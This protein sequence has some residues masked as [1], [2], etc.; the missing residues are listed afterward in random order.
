VAPTV[1][2]V[3]PTR[4]RAPSLVAALE[5]A[6]AQHGA[7]ETFELEVI[8]VD[9][10]SDLDVTP[11]VGALFP[12]AITSR[13]DRNVG[14]AASRNRALELATGTYVAFLDD[15]DRW[16]P[17]KTSLQLAA[18]E[19]NPDAGAVY[20]QARFPGG[21]LWPKLPQPSGDVFGQLLR[22]PISMIH[23]STLLVRREILDDVGHF[24]PQW[25]NAGEDLDL[26]FRLAAR[27]QFEFVAAAVTLDGSSRVGLTT[28]SVGTHAAK[29]VLPSVLERALE[30]VQH[31]ATVAEEARAGLDVQVAKWCA[32]EQHPDDAIELLARSL[33]AWPAL[34]H[35]PHIPPLLASV[36]RKLAAT[37]PEARAAALDLCAR[38]GD[39]PVALGRHDH[40]ARRVL[41]DLWHATARGALQGSDPDRVA[42]RRALINALA[43]DPS[44]SVRKSTWRTGLVLA[45][46]LRGVL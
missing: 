33:P 25:R 41:A 32:D 11:L 36:L 26:W 30:L 9:D 10:A 17:A 31:D 5:S 13:F 44:T 22:T 35:V 34:V 15:D 29:H 1:S 46:L 38:A 8:V 14:V 3:V 6:Y 18:L 40:V 2:V 28:T 21:G 4:N 24:D 39:D 19:R 37:S 23:M 27:T 12:A 20:G 42:A 7:G 45:H 43:T 16:L